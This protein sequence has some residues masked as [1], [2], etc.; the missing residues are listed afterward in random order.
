MKKINALV[1]VALCFTAIL[2]AVS[3]S[4]CIMGIIPYFPFLNIMGRITLTLLVI[5]III[6]L[7]VFFFSNDSGVVGHYGFLNKST[8]IQRISAIAMMILVH[9]HLI[10]GFFGKDGAPDQP[11]KTILCIFEILFLASICLH[12]SLSVPKAL[13]TLGLTQKE[14]TINASKKISYVFIALVFLFCLIG[15]AVYVL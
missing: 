6:S 12:I 5:H 15:T 2:H 1:S 13:I 8:I 3:F 7:C 9:V 4:G 10:G 11:L 14:K